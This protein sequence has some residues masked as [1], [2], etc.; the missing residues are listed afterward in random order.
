MAELQLRCQPFLPLELGV[1]CEIAR[2]YV[3][4][5]TQR[6][7]LL[8]L[9]MSSNFWLGVH[10][11]SGYSG[12]MMVDVQV[13]V[14]PPGLVVAPAGGG[15]AYGVDRGR[16]GAGRGGPGMARGRPDAVAR[17]GIC[18]RGG[19]GTGGGIGLGMSQPRAAPAW[20]GMVQRE[21]DEDE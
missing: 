4:D 7:M 20:L 17:G 11:V 1:V 13:E 14:K 18:G 3:L 16:Q 19:A 6:W 15:A 8:P 12:E 21:S 10:I 5:N 9:R 2:C